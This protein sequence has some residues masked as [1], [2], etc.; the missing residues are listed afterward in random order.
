M[1]TALPSIA[2]VVQAAQ[3][4]LTDPAW[5]HIRPA[6][7]QVILAQLRH[8]HKAVAV[9]VVVHLSVLEVEKC[10]GRKALV[11]MNASVEVHLRFQFAVL[12]DVRTHAIGALRL[13]K[14]YINLSRC[15]FVS[16]LHAR[17]SL[18]HL[19]RL[20]PGPRHIAQTIWQGCAS[21][22]GHVLGEHLHVRA[23]QSEQ[24]YLLGAGGSVAVADVYRRI[25]CERLAQI[26][27]SRTY[28]LSLPYYLGVVNPESRLD[29]VRSFHHHGFQLTSI[30]YAIGLRQHLLRHK[31]IS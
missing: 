16:V 27:A 12:I 10:C 21:Q 7:H 18:A 2:L 29:A 6:V 15:A 3:H 4:Q 1:L 22:V 30:G 9:A 11:E 20:H 5:R 28:Q 24:L 14:L 23:A 13:Q 26:A 25:G 17:R 8:I 19:Y 31:R